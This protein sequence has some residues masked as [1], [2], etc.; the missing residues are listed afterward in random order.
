LANR[1]EI[2]RELGRGGMATVYLARD[3]RHQRSVALKVLRPEVSGVL[4]A[5]RFAREIAI[6][7]RLNHPHI[8][9]IYD[10]GTLELPGKAPGLFYTMPYVAGRS[11]RDRLDDEPQ[12]PIEEAVAIARQVAEA[13]DHAHGLG[14]IH[15]DIK[16]ENILLA[17]GQAMVADFGI[18]RAMDAA[19]GERLTETGLALGTPTYMSPEQAAGSS[20]LDGRTDVYALGCVLYEMLGGQPPF[21]GPTGQA[22][23]ARHAMDPVPSLRTVRSTVGQGL[24]RVVNRALAKVPADRYPSARAFADALADPSSTVSHETVTIITPIRRPSGLRRALLGAGVLLVA[25]LAVAVAV[26]TRSNGS[27]PRAVDPM[28]VAVAPFRVASADSSL[29]YLREGMVDLLATKLA[30]TLALRPAD[31]RASLGAWR[32]AA[33]GG[34][35]T[36]SAA[37]TAAAGLGA[38]RLVQGEV[39][40]SGRRLTLSAVVVDVP[41]GRAR[42]RAAVEG[43]ADS[44]TGMVDQ[45]AARLL[46]L[47]AG[48]PED[49]L[50]GL[51]AV[52][53]SALRAYIDGQ[54][55][56]K[57]NDFFSSL[58]RFQNALAADSTF[59]NAAMGA[60]RAS[61][62]GEF[63]PRSAE[64]KAAWRLRSRLSPRDQAK[65]DVLLGPGYPQRT[66]RNE[67]VGAA[68]R[69]TQLASDDPDAWYLYGLALSTSGPLMSLSEALPRAKS[70]FGRA[71][72]L[73]S[74]SVLYRTSYLVAAVAV[75]D[76]A[77]MRQGLA[78]LLRTDST[79]PV[80][81][82]AQWQVA[83]LLGD[84]AAARRAARNDSMVTTRPGG[85]V[86]DGPWT[87][88]ATFLHY[89]LGLSDLQ[90]VLQR[91]LA[92][93]PTG[94]QRATLEAMAFLLALARGRSTGVPFAGWPLVDGASQRVIDGLF[95]DGD[96]A[97]AAAAAADLERDLGKPLDEGGCLQRF[98]VGEYALETGRIGTARRALGDLERAAV[99]TRNPTV[100]VLGRAYSAILG[101]Q[102]SVRDRSPARDERIRVLDS[103]M[104]DYP[105]ESEWVALI[106]NLVA[107]R[108]HQQRGE[109]PEA[110]AAVRRRDHTRAN[111]PAYVTY[112]REEGRIAAVAGD[113]LGAIAAYQRY[114]RIR[115]EAEPRLQ[116][117]VRQGREELAALTSA[118]RP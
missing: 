64:A 114:L 78:L 104:T 63:D 25:G 100:A 109:Y 15:R 86:A 118:I 10:S 92:D 33:G 42:A 14:I 87:L 103:V 61:L 68:E 38:G 55:L 11:V 30:G 88:M 18:A 45:L 69:F 70:A 21:T 110:L 105:G 117:E 90:L 80:S 83:T 3:L 113:T 62:E 102:L 23:L 106:G 101:A 39:V 26:M 58:R 74:S 16:P 115:A 20:R 111:M 107:A 96:S 98:A 28:V 116:A 40:G 53:L 24:S 8:L 36:E 77:A 82:A 7:A 97:A 75:P 13:L 71:L 44:L 19:G 47:A 89:G 41:G 66:S 2:E 54:M 60:V 48:E 81:V 9:A 4:G 99:S 112:H 108:L 72:A 67:A 76:T 22:I 85:F 27:E 49:R 35:L 94:R 6:A 34:D 32:R 84:T 79:S 46:A 29:A 5:E 59:A 95:A 31:P 1:Y 73:D 65:L 93:A 57:R 91:S 50:Q 37:L 56:L 17:E 43:A 51:T 12:L 52:S